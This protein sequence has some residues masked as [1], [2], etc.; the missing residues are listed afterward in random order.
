MQMHFICTISILCQYLFKCNVQIHY[1]TFS[2]QLANS[3]KRTGHPK[4][5]F[6]H[7]LPTLIYPYLLISFIWTQTNDFKCW[8]TQE[9]KVINIWYDMRMNKLWHFEWTILLIVS[10]KKV[11]PTPTRGRYWSLYCTEWKT[12]ASHLYNAAS[13][14]TLESVPAFH[15]C[16]IMLNWSFCNFFGSKVRLIW[17]CKDQ[18]RLRKPNT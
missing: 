8:G 4:M 7:K 14:A 13:I 3:L 16:G 15:L 9:K 5:K 18:V 17:D 12:P 2:S 10:C 11:P 6:F 1:K